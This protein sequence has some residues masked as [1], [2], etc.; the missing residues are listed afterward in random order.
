[1]ETELDRCTLMRSSRT[2]GFLTPGESSEVYKVGFS[3]SLQIQ[4]EHAT[5]SNNLTYYLEWLGNDE[6]AE[7]RGKTSALQVIDTERL[8]SIVTLREQ[9]TLYLIK[10]N[11]VLM[12]G[13]AGETNIHAQEAP[14]SY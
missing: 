10:K 7:V 9:N 4:I 3:R 6:A 12:V 8:E 13:W 14:E 5:G 1:M 2:Y 11:T